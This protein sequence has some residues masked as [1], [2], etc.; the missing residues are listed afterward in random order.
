MCSHAPTGHARTPLALEVRLPPPL[1]RVGSSPRDAAATCSARAPKSGS[2]WPPLNMGAE[3]WPPGSLQ[4]RRWRWGFPAVPIAP[5]H[6]DDNN[7]A[8]ERVT[9]KGAHDPLETPHPLAPTQVH[10]RR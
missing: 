1:P 10:H 4:T 9:V 6:M 7:G 5:R 3:I 8:F 2:A